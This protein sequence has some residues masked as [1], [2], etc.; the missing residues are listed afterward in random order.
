MIHIY[1]NASATIQEI[2]L[3]VEQWLTTFKILKSIA[4]SSFKEFCQFQLQEMSLDIIV[5]FIFY[6]YESI[7]SLIFS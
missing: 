2:S 4:M 7:L 1:L 3:I 6:F 5:L